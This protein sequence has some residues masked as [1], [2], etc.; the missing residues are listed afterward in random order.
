MTKY[1]KTQRRSQKGGEWYNPVSWFGTSSGDP[2]APKRTWGQWFSGT[3]GSAENTLTNIGNNISS[4]TT[5]MMN[6]ANQLLSSN[7]DLT[8]S[9]PNQQPIQQPIQK[10]IQQITYLFIFK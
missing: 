10:S 1:R 2:Y 4:G 8:G 5:N 3:T 6:S 7:V 9:Q